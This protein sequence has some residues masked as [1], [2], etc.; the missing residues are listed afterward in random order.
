MCK[1]SNGFEKSEKGFEYKFIAKGN[2][3][4]SIA[5]GDHL[6]LKVRY[7]NRKDSMLFNTDELSLSGDF[8]MN[9]TNSAESGLLHDAV[10]LMRVGDSAHFLIPADNF[11]NKTAGII[12]PDFIEEGEFLTF[13][14]S[15]VKKY[16]DE[17][18]ETEYELY[19]LQLEAKENHLLS[20]YLQVEQITESPTETGL[21][22]IPLEKGSGE[23]AVNGKNMFVHYQ[24]M[25]INGEVFDSS[26][27]KGE[28]LE[29]TLGKGD[30]IPA[31]EEAVST[32]RVGDKIKIIAPSY[33]AY[34]ERG[35]PPYIPAYS[36][37]IFEMKLV[38]V[39]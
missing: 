24:G 33:L 23:K 11:Y 21:Y 3:T 37:L 14:I 9:V 25:L 1:D 39:K 10:K 31:W 17:E 32:M 7:Y 27:E 36:T 29:F 28:P 4:S 2:D 35:Y 19:L 22:I 30:V 18:L 6:S 12:T 20:E 13:E 34:G 15:V 38:D 26:L 8:R 5:D 16:T